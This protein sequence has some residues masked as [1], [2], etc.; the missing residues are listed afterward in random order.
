[1]SPRSLAPSYFVCPHCGLQ[2][3]GLS[4]EAAARHLGQCR[5][6]KERAR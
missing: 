2:M 5:K 6:A 1:M 4:I 3:N